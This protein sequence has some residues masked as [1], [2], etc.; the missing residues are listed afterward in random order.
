MRSN[1]CCD[2]V[3]I[4]K[5]VQCSFMPWKNAPEEMKLHTEAVMPPRMAPKTSDLS[6][7]PPT[8]RLGS[9]PREDR[10]ESNASTVWVPIGTLNG[11]PSLYAY[12]HVA[13]AMGKHWQS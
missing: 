9:Q 1:Y 5:R 10:R 8:R 3:F 11:Q 12:P 2:F 6:M 7:G 4:L 13:Y